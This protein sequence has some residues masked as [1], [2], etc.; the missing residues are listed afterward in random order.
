MARYILKRIL[1]LIPVLFGVTLLV[2][3]LLYFA[4]GDPAATKLGSEAT[5]EEIQ[6]LRE[7]W[8]LNDSYPVRFG[9]YVKQVLIDHDLGTSYATGKSISQDIV[10]RFKI[11]FQIAMISVGMALVFG[12]LM[13][14]VA[15]VKQYSIWDNASMVAALIGSSMPGFWIG[16][17]MSI[18]FALKLGWFPASGWGT[19]KQMLLPCTA[20]AIGLAGGLARQTRSSMLEVIRQDYITT[21]R[22]KG[23]SNLKVIFVHAFRNALIPIVT[24]AGNVLGFSLGGAVVIEAVFSIPGLGMY[25]VDAINKRDYP[26]IQGSTLYMAVVFG[27]V[28][29]VVDILYALIDPRIKARYK[30]VKKK[31]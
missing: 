1:M 16:L 25:M 24:A 3:T 14:I 18:L 28:M 29:L 9:R 19:F 23:I 2:F 4:K 22:A 11:T 13:G 17:L 7:E 20:S 8:G 21:A 27:S 6:E 31:V 10:Y 5:E 15:A 12:V 30:T 26:A